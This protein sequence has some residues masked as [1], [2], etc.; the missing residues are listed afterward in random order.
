MEELSKNISR[1]A[2]SWCTEAPR[3]AG[4]NSEK[5]KGISS[6]IFDAVRRR[7]L[8]VCLCAA[9][10]PGLR[11]NSIT[12]TIQTQPVFSLGGHV[13]GSFDFD[14]STNAYS[15]ILLTTTADGPVPACMETVYNAG[16]ANNLEAFGTSP[17]C[18]S[19]GGTF[20]ALLW[21]KPHER[22]RPGND[23]QRGPL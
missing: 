23:H 4:L 1:R 17:S 19:G 2:A 18:T 9:L 16:A 6:M 11:A 14:A 5:Q 12:W 10:G 20:S 21:V 13:S 15:N 7:L 22:R 3:C 8:F